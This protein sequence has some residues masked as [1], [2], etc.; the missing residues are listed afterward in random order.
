MLKPQSMFFQ[1]KTPN[2]P[3]IHSSLT[4][5]PCVVKAQ[6]LGS[7]AAF[8]LVSGA[9]EVTACTP[10]PSPPHSHPFTHVRGFQEVGPV[11]GRCHQH[12]SSAALSSRAPSS[13]DKAGLS[14]Y[15][16]L[17]SG[18]GEDPLDRHVPTYRKFWTHLLKKRF[19]SKS[20]LMT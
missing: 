7:L 9:S 11:N 8:M 5:S 14:A 19:Q 6:G 16:D 15:R 2:H 17:H 10:S 1:G 20:L 4:A 3:I 13:P 12:S 18:R